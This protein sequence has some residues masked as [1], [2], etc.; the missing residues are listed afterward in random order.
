LSKYAEIL[1]DL[2]RRIASGEYAAG[3][4]LPSVREAAALYGCSVN[5][6]V[7]AYAELEKRHA[8]YSIPRSGHY[9]V[10]GP[11]GRREAADGPID[12]SAST[13]DPELFPLQDFRHCLNQAL[14]AHGRELF[15]CA[16]G[17]GLEPLRQA[18][19]SHFAEDQVFAGAERIRIVPGVN[20]ALELLARMPFPNGNGTILVEQPSYDLYLRFLEEAGI[21]VR[22]IGRT[23]EGV[24]LDELERLFRS[25]GIKFFY[26]MT[27]HHSPL[28]ASY[29]LEERKAIARL[30]GK[31]GVYVV[32]DDYLADMGDARGLDPIHAYDR[33]GHV[34]YLK[35]F[36]KTVFPG[37]RLGAAVLPE[38]LL[39]PFDGMRRYGDTPPL[40]QAALEVYL[41]SGM[42]ERHRRMIRNRYAERMRALAA[43]LKLHGAGDWP[44]APDIRPGLYAPL[45]LPRT[46]NLERLARRLADRGV[47][48]VSGKAGYLKS[49]RDW[50]KFLRL[51]V[52]RANPQRIEEGV[53]RIAEEVRREAGRSP[54]GIFPR[55]KGAMRR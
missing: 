12:L 26:T 23:A 28:G 4:K 34:I 35:S 13:P 42:Y 43:A 33:S 22:G 10:D 20:R 30:A 45:M 32:E 44:C 1:A 17:R 47:R 7:R 14:D 55:W 16:D 37:L 38:R 8:V 54:E 19:A 15:T 5:T 18:L 6:M 27:R 24:D 48:V 52:A 31:Y 39:K 51:S 2:E 21:P 46:V 11:S 36:S 40:T 25:G 50:M 41:R 29:S 49:Y 9:V 3:R 53:R